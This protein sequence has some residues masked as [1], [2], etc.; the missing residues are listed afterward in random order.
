MNRSFGI[1]LARALGILIVM[2][3]HYQFLPGFNYGVYAI[4]FLFVISGYLIGQILLTNFYSTETVEISS[5]K[6]FMLRRWFRILPLYYVAIFIKFMV[7]PQIGWNLLYYIFFLQNH[8]YGIDFFPETWSLVI[9]EWFYLGTP[10]I[11]YVFMRF[12]SNK[13]IYILIYLSVIIIV[14]NLLRA[15]WIYK[16]NIPFAGL[17]G[18]IVLHQDTL[19]IGV[20][21][22]FIK[23]QLPKTFNFLNN[24]T[25]FFSACFLII[26]HTFI[27]KEIRYPIDRMDSYHILKIVEFSLFAILIASTLPY[28]ENSVMPFKSL[29]LKPLNKIIILGSKLSY[30]LYLFHGLSLMLVAFLLS[31]ITHNYVLIGIGG[32]IISIISSYLLYQLVEKKFLILRDKYYP[33][34]IA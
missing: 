20:I 1:D 13:K 14:I 12:I 6:R 19:L 30:A 16:T 33:D 5:V 8:F 17:G 9:D 23:I 31:R 10:I 11:L 15:F 22:A 27:L 25:V 32:F 4:E 21:L 29:I 7:H 26:I 2:L 24:K 34:K 3:R 28:L 18:N